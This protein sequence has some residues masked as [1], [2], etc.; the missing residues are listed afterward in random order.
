VQ[1]ALGVGLALIAL[2]VVLVLSGSPPTVAGTN[3]VVIEGF[4][5]SVPGG[6]SGCQPSGTV[7][8]GT[9]AMRLSLDSN[10]GPKVRV[11]VL[12]GSQ[13]IT[14]GERG[15]GWGIAD[16]VTVPVKR[17]AQTTPN[18]TTC[19][20]IGPVVEPLKI[21][22]TGH[23]ST[24]NGRTGEGGPFRIEYLHTGDKSWWS[25]LSSVAHHMGLGH[26]PSGT[27]IVFLLLAITIAIA[28]LGSRLILRE[29]GGPAAETPSQPTSEAPAASARGSGT[30]AQAA[31][32]LRTMLGR[33]PRAAWICALIACL[34]AIS[35]SVLTP[36]FQVSD[37]PAHFA[38]VQHLAETGTLPTAGESLYE[39][40]YSQEEKVAIKALRLQ[41]V[42]WHP[43]L[44]PVATQA[45]Q[46]QLE[47]E[48]NQPLSRKGVGAGV[49]ASQ[50]PLYYALE[51]I[52][53]WL[54]SSGTLLDR[55]ALMRLLSALMGGLTALFA[56]L[57]VRELLP[58][59]RWAWAVG[60]LGA[61]L[62]P[63][64]GFMS[65][66]V[67]PDAMLATVSAA[68]FYC[69][70]R[71]FRRGLT[72]KLAVAIG[73]LTAIGFL[74]KNNFVGLAP[75]VLLGLVVLAV[76]AARS[77]RRTAYRSLALG[78]GIAASPVC[79]YIIV[80]LLSNHPGLG[81]TSDAIH[82]TRE[83]GS[84]FHEISYIWQFFLPRLP[85]MGN[86]FPGIFAPRQIWFDRSVGLYGWLD[87]PFPGWVYD[88][89]LIPALLLAILAIRALVAGGAALRRRLAELGV[90]L[91][92][93][94]GLLAVVG[95]DSYLAFPGQA[96]TYGEPRYLLPLI[97][98]F[99]AALAL[100]ARGA[101][102]RWGP[103]VGTLIVLLLLAH[104]IFSQLQVIG[105]FYV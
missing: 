11:E 13:V 20:A 75:G 72:P 43:E 95:A 84:I 9:S 52:P 78:A 26:A 71:G 2:A 66:A 65:G 45:E 101:G 37:E 47:N 6:A 64:L 81:I 92:M 57:F 73:A 67:N 53:Y 28:L 42:R 97:V 100:S 61:A 32:G 39:P 30:G 3:S 87:T 41:E 7:P 40:S 80:N 8:G 91:V 90:Y 102:K 15:S 59:V 4:L 33:I 27:W 29:L 5:E 24:T 34:N 82:M 99:A 55:L 85:G 98:L 22:G 68:I 38:Y 35:W 16:T 63:L 17:V 76:R 12:S 23:S 58:R 105:R 69:L 49:A 86:D 19:L 44:H 89:A 48:L 50:P 31:R 51:A 79:V 21:L 14:H 70:A 18:T 96:G 36:P 1:V 93:S 60:G 56:Y 54:G 77:D 103:A 83:Q 10:L 25:L 88:F 94:I 74:T 62:T 104:N 46:Q